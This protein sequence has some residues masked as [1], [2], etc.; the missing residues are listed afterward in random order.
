MRI[1][2]SRL[3]KIISEEL[4]R[5]SEAEREEGDEVLLGSTDDPSEWSVPDLSQMV[6]DD[7]DPS[8][9]GGPPAP[10]EEEVPLFQLEEEL[11]NLF[12][13]FSEQLSL[14]HIVEAITM[15]LTGGRPGLDYADEEVAKA[16][17]TWIYQQGIG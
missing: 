4:H 12:S 1:T 3:E 15:A 2:R 9:W 13:Q 11:V 16:M 7:A 14:N 10:P 6:D 17:E 5:M 8:E